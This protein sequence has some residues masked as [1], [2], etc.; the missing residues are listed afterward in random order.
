M[1]RERIGRNDVDLGEGVIRA[2][3]DLQVEDVE[4]IFKKTYNMMRMAVGQRHTAE[5][6]TSVWQAARFYETNYIHKHY[7]FYARVDGYEQIE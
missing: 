1:S 7:T 4:E 3:T 2:Q 6:D 5:K